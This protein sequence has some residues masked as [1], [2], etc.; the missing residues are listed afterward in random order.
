MWILS[1][2]IINNQRYRH[3]SYNVLS[4]ILYYINNTGQHIFKRRQFLFKNA[5]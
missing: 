1:V 5:R 2:N 4:L 3:T